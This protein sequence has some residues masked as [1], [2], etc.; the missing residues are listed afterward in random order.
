MP[1][2]GAVHLGID[3]GTS[4]VRGMAIDAVGAVAALASAPLPAP[5][6]I[7]GG[8]RQDPELWWAAVTEVIRS[9]AAAVGGN[10]VRSLAVDGTSGTLLLTDARW[11]APGAGRDVQRRQ[12]RASGRA[13]RGHRTTRKRCAWRHLTAGTPPGAPGASIPTPAT[14]CIRRTGSPPA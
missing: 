12:R 8:L 4:G 13:D 6:A 3:V 5:L 7:A 1:G 11:R 2:S 14:R 10:R 9:V